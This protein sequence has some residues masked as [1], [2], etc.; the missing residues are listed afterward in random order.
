V[1]IGHTMPLIFFQDI[2]QTGNAFICSGLNSIYNQYTNYSI[3]LG[4]YVTIPITIIS[5]FG[6]LT[7]RNLCM[8]S[9]HNRDSLSSIL[10]QMISMAFLQIIVLVLFQVPLGIVLT[11]F[12]ATSNLT[13]DSY[14]LTQEQVARTFVLIFTYGTLAVN[15]YAFLLNINLIF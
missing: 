2:I 7:H 9:T 10:R 15:A 4:L 12:L 13:K 11:Y 3:T 6:Y 8:L 1:W 5:V 14:R